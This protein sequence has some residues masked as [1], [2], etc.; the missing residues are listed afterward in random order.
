MKIKMCFFRIIT[1][2]GITLLVSS[3]SVSTFGKFQAD[4]GIP[5]FIQFGKTTREEIMTTLGEPLVHRFV[6]G[7]ETL[8]TIMNG[9]N[10]FFLYGTYE[11]NE[12]VIRLT[13]Q[14]VYE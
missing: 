3:C 5:S 13:D 12:L 2:F 11:G 7:K 9:K 6:V 1:G 4:E 10:T 8:T 14:I